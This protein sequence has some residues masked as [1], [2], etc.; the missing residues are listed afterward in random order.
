[1]KMRN[2][3]KFLLTVV[4]SFAFIEAFITYTCISSPSK[5]EF[6]DKKLFQ[7]M[8][9][10][11]FILSQNEGFYIGTT[12]DYG[13]LG[14][15]YK[16][17]KDKN[18]FRIV[19]LGNSYVEAFQLYDEYSIRSILE[20]DLTKFTN[21]KIEVLNFARSGYDFHQM[22]SYYE[23][24]AKDFEPDLVLFFVADYSMNPGKSFNYVDVVPKGDSVVLVKNFPDY[25]HSWK[26]K[27]KNEFID[28][29]SL[30]SL[31]RGAADIASTDQVPKILFDK[32]YT[33]PAKDNNPYSESA[34]ENPDIIN[35]TSVN[36]LKTLSREASG[37]KR[38]ALVFYKPGIP[39]RYLQL[40]DSLNVPYINAAPAL[41][42]L[43]RKGIDP[44]YWPITHSRGHWNH[45]G[46]K[47]VGNVL[48]KDIN[49]IYADELYSS[50]E[51]K[52]TASSNK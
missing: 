16:P 10:N 20:R 34:K 52:F 41:E 7:R 30:I 46:H 23:L 25:D 42:E 17:R 21:K 8:R 14:P 26:W 11:N 48:V 2:I 13:Y 5:Y 12:N 36:I 31:F 40:A 6:G 43:T 51:F 24:F 47:T 4:I 50:Q 19:L 32:L 28:R 15:S 22:Y 33:P 35:G 1:M 3:I 29:S 27:L 44:E 18:T 38:F 9:S 45:L 49:R 37:S 39:Q